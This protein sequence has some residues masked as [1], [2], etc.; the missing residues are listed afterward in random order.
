MNNLGPNEL[1]DDVDKPL[2]LTSR[3]LSQ[4]EGAKVDFYCINFT[5]LAAR[6]IHVGA[7]G[8]RLYVSTPE[9]CPR[10]TLTCTGW[11]IPAGIW[12]LAA[13]ILTSLATSLCS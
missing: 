1:A 8:Q 6:D 7:Q 10:V 4:A 9:T 3:L 5:R 11:N 12:F 2:S 13:E